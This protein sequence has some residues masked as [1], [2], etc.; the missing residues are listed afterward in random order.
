MLQRN[1]VEWKKTHETEHAAKSKELKI[2]VQNRESGKLEE[3]KIP[4]YIRVAMRMMYSTG[5]GLY[6]TCLIR[7][8]FP[9]TNQFTSPTF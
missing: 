2:M 7:V 9:S 8:L 5:G 4:S 3:E 6:S 1:F